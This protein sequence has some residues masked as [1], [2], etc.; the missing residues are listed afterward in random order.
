MG[1]L[2]PGDL[3]R[4]ETPFTETPFHRDPPFTEILPPFTEIS[5]SQRPTGQRPP[6]QRPPRRN[7][8]SGTEISR[9]SMGPG[10]QTVSNIIQRSPMN[11]MTDACENITFPHL[12]WRAL[13]NFDLSLRP[14]HIF[15]VDTLIQDIITEKMGHDKRMKCHFSL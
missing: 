2:C 10:T 3:H 5:L 8:A 13:I 7:M 4:T 1:G 14:R 15:P 11:R 6:S 9:S 12:R